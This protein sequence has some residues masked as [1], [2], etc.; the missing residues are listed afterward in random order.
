[1][2]TVWFVALAVSMCFEGLGRRYLPFIPS[3]AFYFLKDVV[4]L[5]GYLQFRPKRPVV[6]AMRQLYQGFEV[7]WAVGFVWTV[8]EV[9]NPNGQSIMLAIVGL[10]SYWLWWMAP[11]VIASVLQDEREK[12][13]AIFA[14]IGISIVVAVFAAIQFASPAN[15]NVNMYTVWNGEEVYSSDVAIVASTGRAR[16]ASTFAYVTGFSDFTALVPALLLSLGLDS[17]S[18]RV[19]SAAF[20]GSFATA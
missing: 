4:L 16:V 11:V 15:S 13:H 5:V 12:R 8:A 19:R 14:L 17:S 6:R 18:A 7:F 10:R 20:L 3:I 9:F 1:M 2:K